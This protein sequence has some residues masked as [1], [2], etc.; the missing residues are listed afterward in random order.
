MVTTL[1]VGAGVSST[2]DGERLGCGVGTRVGRSETLGLGVGAKE[3]ASVGS[4][5]KIGAKVGDL[6][7]LGVLRTIGIDNGEAVGTET[8]GAIVEMATGAALGAGV[9]RM[10]E[11]EG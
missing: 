5:E 10:G 1:K 6:L 8:T 11:G 3:S 7:G 9:G 4:C 2:F